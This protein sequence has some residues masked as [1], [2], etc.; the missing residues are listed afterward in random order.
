MKKVIYLIAILLT[1]FGLLVYGLSRIEY[2]TDTGL[3]LSFLLPVVY[4]PSV[5]GRV[6]DVETER[7]MKG[8]NIRAG[9]VTGYADPGGGTE[10]IFKVYTPK[11]DGDG[12]F[13]L[14]WRRR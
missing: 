6:I 10:R 11:T 14:P 4:I 3:N 12:E 7:P 9:W 2:V 13:V 1:G 5:K 8:V